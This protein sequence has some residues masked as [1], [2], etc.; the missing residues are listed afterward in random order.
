MCDPSDTSPYVSGTRNPSRHRNVDLS[1]DQRLPTELLDL[2]VSLSNRKTLL[3][4]CQTS[5]TFQ[6]LTTPHLYSRIHVGQNVDLMSLGNLLLKSPTHAALVKKLSVS[7]S[8]GRV[9]SRLHD[10]LGAECTEIGLSGYQTDRVFDRVKQNHD[11][12]SMLA[13]MLSNLPNLQILDIDFGSG[14][15]EEFHKI[16]TT[17]ASEATASRP[18][19]K[20]WTIFPTIKDHK[21][22]IPSPTFMTPIDVII[23]GAHSEVP[24]LDLDQYPY[25]AGHIPTFFQLPNLRSFYAW[26]LTDDNVFSTG[27][28]PNG[29]ESLKP[30]TSR[31]QV[32]ELRSCMLSM[33]NLRLL[34][35][36]T[37]PGILKT[38]IYEVGYGINAIVDKPAEM[39]GL[40]AHCRTLVN[41]SLTYASVYPYFIGEDDRIGMPAAC[42]FVRFEALRSLKI[43]PAFLWGIDRLHDVS[44]HGDAAGRDM[45]WK[46]LPQG[47]VELWILKPGEKEEPDD[48]SP[49]FIPELLLP[50]LAVL[51]E[52]KEQTFSNL[53][54]LY[55]DLYLPEWELDWLN[56]LASICQRAVVAGFQD[57]A[58]MIWPGCKKYRKSSK[59]GWGWNEDIHWKHRHGNKEPRRH[60]ID[61]REGE[62]LSRVL[63][64]MLN[65]HKNE[66]DED[67]GA[68][69]DSEEDYSSSST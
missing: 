27:T 59:R 42:S 45:L 58:L 24:G 46:A 65:E 2:I 30:T 16:L 66:E 53:D 55:I 26:G 63:G 14:K 20:P 39:D 11:E 5:K 34:L 6:R 29:F 19:P 7:H 22:L 68:D 67:D 69:E 50:A 33:E 56:T 48:I 44:P 25:L 32:I 38:F 35:I 31:V 49:Y 12:D 43:A 15:H 10:V 60:R 37:I 40:A 18:V 54:R 36:A 62:D 57:V 23:S 47:L 64:N 17:I 3:A 9:D 1:F 28:G 21:A 52:Q 41:I 13:L 8:W 51:V 61:C 4:L